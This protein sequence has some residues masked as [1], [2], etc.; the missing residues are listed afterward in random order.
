MNGSVVLPLHD[1]SVPY[2]TTAGSL[3]REAREVKGISQEAAASYLNLMTSHIVAM[4]SDSYNPN[5]EGKH[6]ATYL[7]SYARLLDLNPQI[8][9]GLYQGHAEQ[10]QATPSPVSTKSLESRSSGWRLRFVTV[11]TLL[12][13]AWLITQRGW[14][15]AERLQAA[16]LYLA[17]RAELLLS[18]ADKVAAPGSQSI[19]LDRSKVSRAATVQDREIPKTGVDHPDEAEAIAERSSTSAQA[20]STVEDDSS[21]TPQSRSAFGGHARVDAVED[22][23][24]SAYSIELPAPAAGGGIDYGAAEAHLDT[25][26]FSFNGN[27]WIEVYDSQQNPIVMDTKLEGETLHITGEGPFEVRVGNSRAVTLTLNGDPVHIE[28]HPTIHSTELIVDRG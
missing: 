18:A 22:Q 13:I 20:Q 8:L 9:L 4:E 26:I 15:S 7:K 16:Q 1:H 24:Y 2:H 21:A 12:G 25:L 10:G 28:R 14:V 19:A 27:C 6:F 3:L 17:D 5:L 23:A 11:M